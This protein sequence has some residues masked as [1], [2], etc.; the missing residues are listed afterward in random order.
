MPEGH[1]G[2]NYSSTILPQTVDVTAFQTAIRD[3]LDKINKVSA[4]IPA[5]NSD[6]SWKV[7]GATSQPQFNNSW[8][9]LAGGSPPQFRKDI[10][11][12]VH[13][14]GVLSTGTIAAAAYAL[15]V[16]YRPL[17]THY[18]AVMSNNAFG[19][20]QITAAGQVIPLV[21][22]NAS[23]FLDGTCFLAEQ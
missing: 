23:F 9:A 5:N 3:L 21:G 12:Y 18:F 1:G 10:S 20:V 13:L 15:P 14:S 6:S 8:V 2:P 16:G 7:V 11:G 17:A 19:C 22:S 4:A